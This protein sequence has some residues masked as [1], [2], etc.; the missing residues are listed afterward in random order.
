MYI[1][2]NLILITFFYKSLSFESNLSNN[3]FL[4]NYLNNGFD[5]RIHSEE[6]IDLYE[7]YLLKEKKNLLD[8]L[9]KNI[10]INEKLNLIDNA[11][12]YSILNNDY[13]HINLLAGG[14]MDDF[15]FE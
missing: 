7:L 14:L 5:N 8:N 11:E 15:N 10:S 2:K 12:K 6:E 9:N 4:R 13:I 1:L 3:K